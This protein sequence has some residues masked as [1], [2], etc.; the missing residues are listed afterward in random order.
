MNH[1]E[2]VDWINNVKEKIPFFL[3]SLQGK[4]NRGFYHY[5]L[6]GD[7]RHHEDWGVFNSVCAARILYILNRVSQDDRDQISKHILSFEDNNGAMYDPYFL[8]KY[9]FR[10]FYAVVTSR[11][12]HAYYTIKE[13]AI[14]GLTRSA[15]AGLHCL[16]ISP[17]HFYD[18]IPSN[19]GE[20][21]RY[22][23]KL[24][25]TQP[26]GAGSHFSALIL[27]LIIQSKKMN[28]S[29]SSETLDLI[30]YAFSVVDA[31]INEDGSWG[32]CPEK[33]PAVQKINGCMKMLLAYQWANKK[34]E[35]VNPMI[36][37]CLT[38]EVGGDGCN[39]SDKILV[40]YECSKYTNYKHDDIVQF[41][42]NQFD[43]FKKY[44]WPKEGGFS[45]YEDRSINHLYGA[46]IAHAKPE[47]DIHG[48]WLHLYSLAMMVD[49]CGMKKQFDF[50]IPLI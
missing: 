32:H 15:Y 18:V 20:I 34:P 38:C 4:S 33:M 3:E 45:F 46:K 17:A 36:D 8:K 44:W 48:T 31:L 24:N 16:N 19:E 21:E 7:L 47:P 27:F 29:P 50:Q 25:W 9:W 28:Q 5:T 43:I 37:L 22:I 10:Q 26:W 42:L 14:R 30:D 41:C 12:I 11:D 40:L 49:M 23:N 39:N 1:N 35:K 13:S 2:V 6:S